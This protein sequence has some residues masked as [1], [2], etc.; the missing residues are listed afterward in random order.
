MKTRPALQDDRKAFDYTRQELIDNLR[1][2]GITDERV[3][4]AMYNVPRRYFINQEYAYMAYQDQSLPIGY[5]Q[6]ISQPYVVAYMTQTLIAKDIDTVLEIGTGSGYQAAI[7]AHLVERVFTVERI[8]ELSRKA[9]SLLKKL[10]YKNIHFRASDGSS[11]WQQFAPYQAIIVTA[12]TPTVPEKLY[13]QLTSKGRM[14]IPL[15]RQDEVQ[16]LT[17]VSSTIRGPKLQSLFGV[18]F[19][20]L[21]KK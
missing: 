19:V 2:K 4:E 16:Q 17:L 12:A 15:G 7:L 21:I 10:G 18:Q 11:G 13:Q 1:A 8:P 6:T 9:R 14:I 20:P 5:E 3:L